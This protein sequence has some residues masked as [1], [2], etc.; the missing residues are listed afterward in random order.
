M[1]FTTISLNTSWENKEENFR[2]VENLFNKIDDL[3]D[4]VLLPEMFS[5]GFS[6]NIEMAENKN[7]RTLKWLKEI[8]N[9]YNVAIICSF[10]FKE[11]DKYFNRA[12]FVTPLGEVYFYD[13]RHLFRMGDEER[14]YSSGNNLPIICY[15]GINICITVCYDI[16][17]PVWSRNVGLKYDVL[18]NIANFPKQR[19]KVID[20]LIR[21][22][23]IENLSYAFF[24]NRDGADLTMEYCKS[25]MMVDFKGNEF[26]NKKK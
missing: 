3:G 1:K 22:R 12:F 4:I 24:A 10:P 21:A 5:T 8:T 6:M 17:F 2:K 14:V 13:K 20:P 15:K 16:R 18:V 19:V 26:S 11:K 7:D 23:A 9:K 25:S